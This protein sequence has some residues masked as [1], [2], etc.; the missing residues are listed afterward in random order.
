M[1]IIAGKHRGRPLSRPPSMIT[2]PTRDAVREAIFNMLTHAE[3][4]DGQNMITDA[5]VLDAFAGSG[6]LALEA[7]SRRAKFAYLFDKNTRAL[8]TV[9]ENIWR[10]NEIE[11]TK[12]LKADAIKPPKSPQPA[13]LIFLD[14]PFGKDFVSKCL[15]QLLATGWIA[16]DAIV[17]A[18]I[19]ATETITIPPEFVLLKEKTYGTAIVYFLKVK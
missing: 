13:N 14:P 19:E 6:A 4:A 12:I 17:V 11:H 8:A 16:K 5:I 9:R 1:R 7:L 18:E 15:P 3:W 2:R 10:L